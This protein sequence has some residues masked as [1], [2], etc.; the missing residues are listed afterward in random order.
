MKK[1]I[2]ALVMTLSL[3]MVVGALAPT[4]FA[5]EKLPETTEIETEVETEVETEDAIVDS[6]NTQNPQV[7]NLDKVPVIKTG[8]LVIY[9][10]RAG[11]RV[12]QELVMVPTYLTY[13]PK[14]MLH[15]VP[16]GYELIGNVPVLRGVTLATAF[17]DPII[18]ENPDP[19][20]PDKP[21]P[22]N[23]DKP[24]PEEKPDPENPDPENPDPENPDPENPDPENPD[25]ENPDP[26]NPDPE[27]PDPEN[28]DK[29]NP[30]NPDKPNPENPTPV[31]P[32][33]V[34]PAPANPT[35]DVNPAGGKDADVK[36]TT[37]ETAKDKAKDKAVPKTGDTANVAVWG[38]LV[39]LSGAAVLVFNR[40]RKDA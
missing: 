10:T 37:K 26:E 29:P 14:D 22:E 36:E 21:D 28:P 19:E 12:G 17:V 32:T 6:Q 5:E 25:P 38:S 39:A 9:R 34:N 31:N 23:P 2:V 15:K 24:D 20:N 11:V 16:A 4:V 7:E 35:P 1:K 8:V 33:P 27:N 40:R 3:S 18:P 30:E 13:V